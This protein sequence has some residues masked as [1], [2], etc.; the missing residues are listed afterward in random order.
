[1]TVGDGTHLLLEG[2]SVFDTAAHAVAAIHR[3]CPEHAAL[4]DATQKLAIRSVADEAYVRQIKPVRVSDPPEAQV[5]LRRGRVVIRLD[6]DAPMADLER[7]AKLAAAQAP[8]S[9]A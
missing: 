4:A 7:L 3:S 1:M 5:I 6:S 8:A 9:A 2:L